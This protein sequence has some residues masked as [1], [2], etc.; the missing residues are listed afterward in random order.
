M[1]CQAEKALMQEVLSL[2][3]AA[4]LQVLKLLGSLWGFTVLFVIFLR[5]ISLVQGSSV[6]EQL[7]S[8]ERDDA[9]PC[10]V[11]SVCLFF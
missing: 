11:A 1:I 8:F 10:I 6:C 7:Y 3:K 9:F 5:I 2:R 4:C